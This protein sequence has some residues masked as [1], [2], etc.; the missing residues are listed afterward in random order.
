MTT[1]TKWLGAV[2]IITVVLL[3]GGIF[4]LSR[5][6]SSKGNGATEVLQIDYS[7]GQK[8][9]SD[10]AKVKLTEFSDFECPACAAV[11]PF[12]AK[13]KSGDPD[14]QFIYRHFPLPQ[15]KFARQ[16]ATVAEVAGEEG[17]FWEM[18]D[19]IFE[20]QSQWS[21]LSD[22]TDFFMALVKELGVD[23]NKV[24]Q[25]LEKDVYKSKIN[26]DLSEGRGLGVNSTPT[27]FLNGRKLNLKSFND[28]NTIVAEELKK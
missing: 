6:N 26:E 16:A 7:K 18:H 17:K 19:K 13:F 5:N 23:E 20:T 27:F 24:K 21:K 8:I 9:G 14:I 15:H 25:A 3:F 4:L 28:L 2:L 1:E 11:E 22:A 12:L 10:S